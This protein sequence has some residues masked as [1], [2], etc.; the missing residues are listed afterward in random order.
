[1]N[2]SFLTR[3]LNINKKSRVGESPAKKKE[4]TMEN[5]KTNTKYLLC[6]ACTLA[7]TILLCWALNFID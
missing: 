2:E 7:V 6:P 4:T 1:V 3:Y 5:H